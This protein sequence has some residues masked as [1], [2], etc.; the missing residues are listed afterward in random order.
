MNIS[1]TTTIKIYET[2]VQAQ[3]ISNECNQTYMSAVIYNS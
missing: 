2:M 1:S 3:Y